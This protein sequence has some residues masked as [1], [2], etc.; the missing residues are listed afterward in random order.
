MNL[1]QVEGKA[2]ELKGKAKEKMG[3]A[4]DGDRLTGS[5]VKDEVAGKVQ[6]TWGDVKEAAKDSDKK[7]VDR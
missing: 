4:T 2:K 3:Q 5:G 6:K 7:D 1:D